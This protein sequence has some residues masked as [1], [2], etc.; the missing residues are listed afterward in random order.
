MRS[1]VKVKEL[2]SVVCI[3]MVSGLMA[4]EMDMVSANTVKETTLILTTKVS[5]DL[6]CD[7]AKV[8]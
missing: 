2:G 7:M 1:Q 5:G 6:T 3:T 8:N 4:R